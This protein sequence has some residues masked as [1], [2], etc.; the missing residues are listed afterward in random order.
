[1][2]R[3]R[4]TLGP[5]LLLSAVFVCGIA[6]ESSRAATRDNPMLHVAAG[7]LVDGSGRPVLLRCVNLSPWLIR[8]I[9]PRACGQATRPP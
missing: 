5:I 3:R 1:M 6:A 2:T 9:G 4:G 8:P 7:K